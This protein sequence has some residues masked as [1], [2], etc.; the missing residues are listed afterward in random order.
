MAEQARKEATALTSL[1]E[2]ITGAASPVGSSASRICGTP[3]MRVSLERASR[4]A[5][6]G[7]LRVK[8]GQR[9]GRVHERQREQ[10]FGFVAIVR[11]KHRIPLSRPVSLNFR[12]RARALLS[13]QPFRSFDKPIADLYQSSPRLSTSAHLLKE[14]TEACAGPQLE[15]FRTLSPTPPHLNN[16]L[17]GAIILLATEVAGLKFGKDVI[18]G[19]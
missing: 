8:G 3:W 18:V 6:V 7:K 19:L 13:N 9:D 15:P 12:T 4:L 5:G 16:V 14:T 11:N 1:H 10:A 2:G 17:K